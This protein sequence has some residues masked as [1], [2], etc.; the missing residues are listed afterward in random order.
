MALTGRTA[1]GQPESGIVRRLIAAA[2]RKTARPRHYRDEQREL[3][4]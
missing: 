2:R 4:S 3:F 1:R